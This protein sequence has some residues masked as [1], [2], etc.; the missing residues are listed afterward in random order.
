TIKS[1]TPFLAYEGK[2][3]RKIIIHQIGFERTITDTSRW[4]KTTAAKVAN[5][6]HND[7]KSW[8]IRNNLF[9]REG[10]PLNPYRV[11]DNERYLRDLDFILDSRIY[12]LPLSEESDS[13]D[14]LVTTRD[15]FSLG[16]VFVPYSAT[17]YRMRLQES[18]LGG[19]GQKVRLTSIYDYDRS[20]KVGYEFQY[21]K[22]NV[23]GSFIN[24]SLAYTE[25]NT[26]RS[27]GEENEYGYLFRLD[28][29]LF[30]PFARWTGALEWSRNWSKNNFNE[31]INS[32]DNYR[33]AIKDVWAGYSFGLKK[34]SIKP[35]HGED[36]NRTIIAL[37]AFDQDFSTLPEKTF[38]SDDSM[39]Y[40]DRSN[41]LGQLSFFKQNFYKTRYV[42]GFGRTED[43]PY[44]YRMS[45]TGGWEK[46]RGIQRAYT[47]AE[48][49][50]STVNENGTFYTYTIKLGNYLHED[51]MEDALAQITIS[52]YS[53]L[54]S[55]GKSK[56]RHFADI[57]FAS[58][59][60][61]T[62][63]RG[64]DINDANGIN[65]FKPDS[66]L[67]AKRVRWRMETVVF[68]PWKLLGFHM[69]PVFHVDL[70]YLAQENEKLA[71]KENLYSGFATALR[72]RNENLIFN[73]VEAR[74]YYYPKTVEGITSWRAEFRT[75]LRIKYPTELVTAPST[76]YN[77]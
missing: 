48:V 69:A 15:V 76:V 71:K 22:T 27:V 10:K 61:R 14:I 46:E 53:R 30:N 28:R 68:T 21:Q 34:L 40:V 67:G 17:E 37:R 42:L 65:G 51:L 1:E 39:R 66:L 3:I 55:I 11:A 13:V 5:R 72:A 25:I 50:L 52:R 33:Y 8:V 56:I 24:A 45:L 38:S 7:S 20:P 19:M 43:I 18:N 47:S 44:G 12:V 35:A 31:E 26:G 62:L 75:N 29:P 41:I 4:I 9:I 16:V 70:A 49:I 77:R 63:K 6:L 23:F 58:Q 2:I 74:L 36:R 60:N 73:T 57:G 54:Y 64:L 32:F 59:I